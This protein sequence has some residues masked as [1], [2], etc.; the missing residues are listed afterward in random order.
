MEE[1]GV[2]SASPI[3]RKSGRKRGK[4]NIVVSW[5][6]RERRQKRPAPDNHKRGSQN[7]QGINH[8]QK[9]SILEGGRRGIKYNLLGGM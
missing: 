9:K 6:T 7:C 2:L 1:K 5:R 4:N 3:H 8:P